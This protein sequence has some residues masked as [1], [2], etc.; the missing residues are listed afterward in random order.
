MKEAKEAVSQVVRLLEA[1]YLGSLPERETL[2]QPALLALLR[3][4]TREGATKSEVKRLWGLHQVGILPLLLL[5][6]LLL[7]T[8]PAGPP[9]GTPPDPPPRGHSKQA[10]PLLP[11]GPEMA[12][13]PALPL[14]WHGDCCPQVPPVLEVT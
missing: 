7:H 3:S 12:Y 4:A 11:R 10:I 6:L 14:P 5:L 9:P 2:V 13:L 8:G 1:W